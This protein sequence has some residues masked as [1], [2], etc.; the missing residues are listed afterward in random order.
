MKRAV[1]VWRRG[2]GVDFYAAD[3]AIRSDSVTAV[4]MADG[5]N[6]EPVRAICDAEFNVALAPGLADLK[7]RIF[8][9]GHLGSLSPAVVIGTLGAVELSLEK[10]GVPIAR[11]GVDAAMRCLAGDDVSSAAARPALAAVGA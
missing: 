7:G 1:D 9:I 6:A 5:M 11:G 8:R 4:M 10:A 3:P 2:G